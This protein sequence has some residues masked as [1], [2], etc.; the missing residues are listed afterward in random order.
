MNNSNIF[1]NKLF[2]DQFRKV[3]NNIYYN[4]IRKINLYNA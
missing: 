1:D 2:K 4:F 3:Y